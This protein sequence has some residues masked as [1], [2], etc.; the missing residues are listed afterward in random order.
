MTRFFDDFV[1]A[2]ATDRQV[3]QIVLVTAGLDTLAYG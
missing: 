3:R 2:E 1:L